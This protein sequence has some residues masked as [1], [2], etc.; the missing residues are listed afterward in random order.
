[1]KIKGY[2]AL[3]LTL[4]LSCTEQLHSKKQSDVQYQSKLLAV[5]SV[6]PFGKWSKR[7][8]NGLTQYTQRNCDKVRKV[9]DKLIEELISIG[10]EAGE[11]EKI[12][13]FKTAILKTNK[14]NEAIAGLIETGEREELCEL[15]NKISIACGLDPAQYGNGEGLASEWREW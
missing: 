14:L 5:K 15:T 8:D 13:L 11:A 1:M 6:Y 2:F 7:Y 10:K 9:F 4:L 12:Q 3:I